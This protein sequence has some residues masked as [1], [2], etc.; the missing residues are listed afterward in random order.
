MRVKVGNEL[1]EAIGILTLENKNA[2]LRSKS[3]GKARAA[4]IPFKP[5]NMSRIKQANAND[6]VLAFVQPDGNAKY[7]VP[8][9]SYLQVAEEIGL[10]VNRE[11]LLGLPVS[12]LPQ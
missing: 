2:V 10:Q 1:F 11:A 3:T 12:K 9:P 4:Y 5:E 8:D 7:M 6:E